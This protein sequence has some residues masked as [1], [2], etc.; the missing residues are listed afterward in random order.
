VSRP[1][2]MGQL[3]RA[4]LRRQF[5]RVRGRG[6]DAVAELLRR[7]GPIQSQA[8]RAP[9]V[10]IAARLPG[11]GYAAIADAFETHRVVKGSSI[12]GTVHTCVRE[13]FPSLDAVTRRT[14]GAGWRTVLGLRR[15]DADEVRAEVERWIGDEWRLESDLNAHM[16]TWLAAHESEESAALSKEIHGRFLLRGYSALIRRPSNGSWEMR[17]P[18][19]L[20]HAS[21]LLDLPLPTPDDALDSLVRVYLASYGPATRQ[22]VAW[23]SGE[24]LTRVDAAV[25][26]LGEEVVARPGPNGAT[27]F[28][29]A[30]PPRGGPADPGVRLLPEFDGLVIGYHPKG[31]DRFLD[32]AQVEWIS[33]RANGVVSPGVL[34]HGRLVGLWRLVGS[35]RRRDVEVRP[36]PGE[37]APAESELAGPVAD[38]ARALDVE[39]R[40]VRPVAAE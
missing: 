22:D 5:P 26:R 32:P 30:D 18:W 28:D 2:T 37:S 14:I 16:T 29:L 39:V 20:R 40:D 8:P 7:I 11:V 6:P 24:G 4:T 13:Q 36:F 25:G 12:R 10:G 15:H 1:Y 9:F 35:G 34:H 17:S 38:V 31:R 19:M 27:Y 21:P 23:W 3:R 33:N